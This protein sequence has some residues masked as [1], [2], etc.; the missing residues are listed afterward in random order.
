S[1]ALP[2]RSEAHVPWT[3]EASTRDP[4]EWSRRRTREFD[5]STG[6]GSYH[7]LWWT[8]KAR[9]PQ[10]RNQDVWGSWLWGTRGVRATRIPPRYIANDHPPSDWNRREGGCG[11]PVAPRPA[12]SSVGGAIRPGS[13]FAAVSLDAAPPIGPPSGT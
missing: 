1:R 10:Q 13:P 6:P 4:G 12:G 11:H 9:R 3:A 2:G 8:D 7:D 5:L